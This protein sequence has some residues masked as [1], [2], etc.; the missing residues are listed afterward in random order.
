MYDKPYQTRLGGRTAIGGYA[1]AHA[2]WQEVEG[3]K[4]DAGFEAKRF[5]LFTSTR[6]SDWVRIGAELEFEEGGREIR[7]EYA[8]ID[9]ALHPAVTLRAGMV[10]SPL[11][12]FNLSHDSRGNFEDNNG[13]PAVVGRFAFSPSTR[14]EIGLSAHHGAY[15]IFNLEGTEIDERRNVSIRVLDVEAELLGIQ[16]AGEGAIATIN[17]PPGLRGIYA[18]RQHGWYVEGLREFGRGWVRTIPNSVFGVKARWDLVDFDSRI[19]GSSTAQVTLGANFRITR[20]SVIKFDYVRGR[21]RDQFNN[22]ARH[23]FILGSVATYF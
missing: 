9:L 11:G 17:V 3:L 21:G 10:L 2:R 12:R 5:N 8:A 16:F 22:L 13:S 7:L 18:E 20:E 23:A 4:D 6:V 19:E 14:H 15:N 1:E